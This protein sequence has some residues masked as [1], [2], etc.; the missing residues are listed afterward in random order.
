[1]RDPVFWGLALLSG[2]LAGIAIWSRTSLSFAIPAAVGA[3][4]VG[5]I[6]GLSGLVRHPA[7][8]PVGVAVPDMSPLT[9]IETALS[10]GTLGREYVILML[11]VL[12]RRSRRADLPIRAEND[13]LHLL[14]CSPK[15]FREFVEAR[16]QDLEQSL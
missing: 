7:A 4:I 16:V 2:V 11:D 15:E 13:R 14:Q 12:E 3:L 8:A 1:V 6:A 9:T 10:S 5:M